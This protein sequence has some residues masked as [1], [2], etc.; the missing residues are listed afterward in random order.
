[1]NI[2]FCEPSANKQDAPAQHHGGFDGKLEPARYWQAQL[3]LDNTQLAFLGHRQA[4]QQNGQHHP[5]QPDH[6]S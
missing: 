6:G 4:A 1:M 3:A 5:Q 2:G